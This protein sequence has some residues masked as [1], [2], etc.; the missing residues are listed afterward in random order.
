[1]QGVSRG[2]SAALAGAAALTG[3]AAGA[4]FNSGRPTV[5]DKMRAKQKR[6]EWKRAMDETF[7][8]AGK[9]VSRNAGKAKQQAKA[10]QS[11][12]KRENDFQAGLNKAANIQK[13]MK[14]IRKS[15]RR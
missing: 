4:L 2:Q 9:Q 5:Y 12:I 3:G 14:L 11:K 6:D 15:I 8:G 7:K 1:M 10:R 13:N